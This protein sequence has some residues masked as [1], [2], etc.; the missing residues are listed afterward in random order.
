M[1]KTFDPKK[2]WIGNDRSLAVKIVLFIIWPFATW[3]YCLKSAHTKSS[4]VIFFL[5][6]LLFCWHMAPTSL[7]VT[8]DFN[9]IIERFE[10]S[11]L[12][13]GQLL[14]QFQDYFAG[15][16]GAPK[17]L[18]ET[19]LNWF[20]KLF[21]DNYHFFFL[22]ASIPIVY[23]Q[24]KTMRFITHDTRFKASFWGIVLLLMFIFPR[25]IV[26]A[27]NPRFVTGFWI[28][29]SCSITYFCCG[30]KI[31]YLLPIIITPLFHSGMWVFVYLLL[32]Y[33]FIPKKII[34]LEVAAL[35]SIPFVFFDAG[36]FTNIN[37]SFLP[38]TLR[39][40]A[41]R[42]MSDE[43]Y[44]KH[45]LHVGRSG[46]W[47][48]SSSFDILL[49]ITYGYMTYQIIKNKDKVF[50]NQDSSNLYGFYLYI[51]TVINFIQFV[52][53]L[54]ERYYWFT[55]ILCVLVWFKTFGLEKSHIKEL[56]Y[57]LLACSW[58]LFSRYGYINGGAL[59]VTTP[60]DLYFTP[61]PYLLGK[62]LI[63]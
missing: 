60:L 22:L 1:L 32:I 10:V 61:L 59:Y 39:V 37:L 49:K 31:K 51:F 44:A 25:D 50:N 40:W 19:S 35:I 12:T 5:F 48:I 45:I 7:T 58:G 63:W 57:L 2:S 24:L 6:S 55:R 13:F 11:N 46:F 17:E 15:I 33:F 36:L 30:R 42:Q 41:E 53:I 21:S 38:P 28:A 52:P 8:D 34:I 20:V 4:Y 62:G 43:G 16:E 56:K 54:G 23:C 29:L 47:W 27:Q 18:Y 26:S 14:Q 3:V 9:W